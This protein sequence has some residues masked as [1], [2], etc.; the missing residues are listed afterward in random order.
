MKWAFFRQE[1]EKDLLKLVY[2]STEIMRVDILTKPLR[3]KVLRDH[4][5]AIR[6]GEHI[7]L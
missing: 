4:D 7:K 1:H 5:S 3:G 2:C 6:D